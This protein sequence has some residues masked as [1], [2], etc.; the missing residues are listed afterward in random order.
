MDIIIKCDPEGKN[1][2]ISVLNKVRPIYKKVL[3]VRRVSKLTLSYRLE[4]QY[5]SEITLRMWNFSGFINES[6]K[7][8]PLKLKKKDL[9]YTTG[10][11]IIGRFLLKVEVMRVW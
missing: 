1:V 7:R 4:L 11:E 5:T 10:V 2:Y 9:K 8:S 3:K 6:L